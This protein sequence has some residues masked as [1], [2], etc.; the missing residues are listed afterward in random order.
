MY[1][2]II[3][4]KIFELSDAWLEWVLEIINFSSRESHRIEGATKK[5]L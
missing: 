5:N 2:T 4:Y 1:T 3:C